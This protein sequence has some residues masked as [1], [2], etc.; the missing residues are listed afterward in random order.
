MSHPAAVPV[1]VALGARHAA[2]LALVGEP[3]WRA[4]GRPAAWTVLAVF[5]RSFYCQNPDGA[6]VCVGAPA[7]GAGPLNAVTEPA[8]ALDPLLPRLQP[9]LAAQQRDGV[10]RIAGWYGLALGG[11]CVWRPASVSAPPSSGRLAP[12]LRSLAAR[13]DGRTPLDGLGGLIPHLTRP[14]ADLCPD[15]LPSGAEVAR[16]S[17]PGVLALLK[18]LTSCWDAKDSC[19]AGPPDAVEGLVGLGPGLTPA[20]DDF[21][22][23]ALVALHTLGRPELAR[24]LAAWLLPRARGR[25]H[26]ISLAHLTC[27][28]NGEAA[29]PLHEV[30]AAVCSPAAP[31]LEAGLARLAGIGHT[32][33]WDGLAGAVAAC[34][35][36]LSR[37]QEREQPC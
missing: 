35:A 20:G 26:A 32:S 15:E 37:P 29:A 5:R 12:G 34:A 9:G 36:C 18:W 8:G 7:I 25:T 30:L 14:G 28:A 4:L 19:A 11:A 1:N 21:L 31:G 17:L 10:L 24:R 6:I 23:G 22:G 13:C 3:A 33:G 16:A 2:R 27:A